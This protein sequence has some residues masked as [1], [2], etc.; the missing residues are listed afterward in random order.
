MT[1]KDE[2]LA[3]EHLERFDK[4]LS[5]EWKRGSQL[6]K[7]GLGILLLGMA[8]PFLLGIAAVLAVWIWILPLASNFTEKLSAFGVLFTLLTAISVKIANQAE[9]ILGIAFLSR[10]RKRATKDSDPVGSEEQYRAG[11]SFLK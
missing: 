11:F 1:A 4:W 8:G 10:P 2:D 5:R 7:V 6:G 3:R 9:K